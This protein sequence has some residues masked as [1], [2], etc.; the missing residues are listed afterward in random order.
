M[1]PSSSGPSDRSPGELLARAGWL[2]VESALIRGL[3]H[4]LNGRATALRGLVELLR[5]D[6]D[7]ADPPVLDLLREES[8]RLGEA[9]EL[10]RLLAGDREDQPPEP[11]AL[12]P[13]LESVLGLHARHRGLEEVETVLEVEADGA[14]RVRRTFLVRALL[15]LLG[16]AGWA[17]RE[18]GSRQVDVALRVDV[19]GR[20]DRVVVVIGVPEADTGQKDA[21]G[22]DASA[23][24][25]RSGPR[26]EAAVRGVEAVLERDGAAVDRREG[27]EGAG[28]CLELSL[29]A[30]RRDE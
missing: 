8:T 28:A 12:E 2:A 23:G 9:V 18:A 19:A 3:A 16:A 30:L 25:E 17:A 10:L 4:D 24:T 27:N 26:I 14:V 6:D 15:L 20:D 5:L 29:P 7:G 11:L 22:I 21:A 13:L 1:P